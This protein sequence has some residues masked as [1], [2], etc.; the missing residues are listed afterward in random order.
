MTVADSCFVLLLQRSLL[1]VVFVVD[2]G[3]VVVL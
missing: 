3:A 2:G 1:C